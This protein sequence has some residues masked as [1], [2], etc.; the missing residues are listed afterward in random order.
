MFKWQIKYLQRIKEMTNEQ[1]LLEYTHISAKKD[2]DE[3]S[4][5]KDIWM[6]EKVSSELS[7]RLIENGFLNKPLIIDIPG[8][9]K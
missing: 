5:W 3:Y 1:V 8:A 9:L 4:D 7:E 2:Y 6:Y